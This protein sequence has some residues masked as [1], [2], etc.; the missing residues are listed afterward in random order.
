MLTME[1]FCQASTGV[2]SMEQDKCGYEENEELKGEYADC[3]RIGHSAYKFVLDFG[4]IIDKKRNR[5]FYKRIIMGPEV[6]KSFKETFSQSIKQYEH[7]FGK[8]SQSHSKT[9]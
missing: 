1:P 8:I 2:L 6:A 9:Q 3:F 5:S 4:Q 7:Q